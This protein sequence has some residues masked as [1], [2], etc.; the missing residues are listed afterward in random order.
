MKTKFKKIFSC[1]VVVLTFLFVLVGC[2][3][4]NKTTSNNKTNSSDIIEEI[5][6]TPAEYFTFTEVEG[7]YSVRLKKSGD[8]KAI[9]IPAKYNNKPV[10][11]VGEKGFYLAPFETIVIPNSIKVMKQDAFSNCRNLININFKGTIAEWANITFYN[12]GANPLFCNCW[13]YINNVKQETLV[14]E[15]T[16]EIKPFAFCNGAIAS[17]YIPS[18]VKTIGHSAC[19]SIKTVYCEV[20]E[21]PEGW[22]ERWASEF[23]GGSTSVYWGIKKENIILKDGL[24]YVLDGTQAMLTG[25]TFQVPSALVIPQ[26]IQAN[27]KQYNVTTIRTNSIGMCKVVYIPSSITTIEKWSVTAQA[28][29]CETSSKPAGWHDEWYDEYEGVLY[30]G[31]NKN[32]CVEKDGL[33]YVVEDEK[34]I[35]TCYTQDVKNDIVVP[36]KIT[37]NNRQYDVTGIGDYAFSEFETLVSIDIPNSIT[38]IGYHSFYFCESLAYVYI[39]KNVTKIK[40]FAFLNC[41][42]L[43]FYSEFETEPRDLWDEDWIMLNDRICYWNVEKDD[44]FFQDGLQF[45][46]S[47][48]NTAKVTGY[49]AKANKVIPSTITVNNKQYSVT[50]IGKKAFDEDLSLE[51]IEIPSSIT[52]IE[53]D[54]FYNCGSLKN[55]YIP[56]TVTNIESGAFDFNEQLVVYCETASQP[57]SWN[58]DSREI[59]IY[60]GINKNN[61]VEKDGLIYLVIDGKAT[62]I[63]YTNNL[64]GDVKIPKDVTI[65]GNKYDVISIEAGAFYECESLASIVIPTS[66]TTIQALAFFDCDFLV[67]YCEAETKPEG[68]AEYWVLNFSSETTSVYWGNEWSYVNGKPTPNN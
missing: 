50:A 68:F 58:I 37:I 19:T 12:Y 1:L 67:I 20:E 22:D 6:E 52:S 23:E 32:N 59:R 66:I 13:L 65:N 10:I 39:T 57:E 14:V 33:I 8:L 38:S 54:A 41:N 46:I 28:I 7:G 18:S 49:F 56:S 17:I 36:E 34:A 25:Y 30:W 51:K 53:S 26:T 27:K 3:D 40:S 2:S 63:N 9:S 16:S 5:K 21:K 35:V 4:K 15:G 62:I 31:I 61:C 29:Y 44:I 45:L 60:F 64:K 42:S 48:D 55:I 43:T 24:Q 47:D 11:E